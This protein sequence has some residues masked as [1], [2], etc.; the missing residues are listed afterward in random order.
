MHRRKVLFAAGASLVG[1]LSMNSR[2]SA[3]GHRRKCR[4]CGCE[5][6]CTKVC[7]LVKEE[8]KITS[9]CWGY[10]CEDFCIPGPSEPECE[11]FET[12]D[13][14]DKES[15]KVCA[16]P[17]KLTWISWIPGSCTEVKTKRKQ[18]KKTVTKKVPSFKWVVEDLCAECKSETKPVEV[19]S[20]TKIPKPPKEA[21]AEFIPGIFVDNRNTDAPAKEAVQ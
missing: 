21:G 16:E 6:S 8:K 9:T 1:W 3:H 11:H 19:P 18:M 7:R 10:E 2:L 12:I 14:R 17:K 13:C 15:K 5:N 4:H 20:D